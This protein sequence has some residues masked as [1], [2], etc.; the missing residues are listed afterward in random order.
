MIDD[1]QRARW[2]VNA[3]F[4]DLRDRRFLKYLFDADPKN[5]GAYGHVDAPLDLDVQGE[6]RTAWANIIRKALEGGAGS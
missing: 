2:A 5:C 1:E 4:R 6:I 3:I